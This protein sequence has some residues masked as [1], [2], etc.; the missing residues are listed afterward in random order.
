MGA[1]L[2]IQWRIRGGARGPGPSLFLD[3]TEARRTE[4]KNFGD[5]APHPLFKGLDN[6]APPPP[7]HPLSESDPE[8]NIRIRGLGGKA[9]MTGMKNPTGDF[10]YTDTESH[11]VSFELLL[12]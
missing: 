9:E 12:G 11:A 6:R 8:I 7:P 5:R 4:K 1:R 3:Q 2:G 10:P